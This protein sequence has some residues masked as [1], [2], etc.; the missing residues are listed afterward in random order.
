MRNQQA[1]IDSELIRIQNSIDE[2]TADLKILKETAPTLDSIF[3]KL[4]DTLQKFLQFVGVKNVQNISISPKTYLPVIRNR[5]YENITSGGVRT[6][7]SVGYYLTLLE[8]AINN[9]SNY[10][11]FLMIDTIAKY[12]GKTKEEDLAYTNR[13]EDINEGMNDSSKYENLYQYLMNLSERYEESFQAFIV[14]NDL[15]IGLETRLKPYVVKHFTTNAIIQGT[16]IGFIDD[17]LNPIEIN[18]EYDELDT[19]QKI[20]GD[21][22]FDENDESE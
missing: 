4:A 18:E 2:Y 17:A 6:L 8:Y 7:S 12:I 11:S 16:E 5:N 19:D 1:T 3:S 20:D 14:D 22:F 15:P 10:P 9:T 21:I 13:Q